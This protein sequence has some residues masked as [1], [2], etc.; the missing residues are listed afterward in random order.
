MSDHAE[1]TALSER[2]VELHG[3]WVPRREPT[4]AAFRAYAARFDGVLNE[5]FVICLRDGGAIVGGVNVNNIVRG[6]FQSGALGYV[7][8]TP[9]AGHGYLT[10]GVA[11]VVRHAF[12]VLGLHRLEA[13]VQPGN[14]RSLRLVRRLGFRYEGFSPA[15]L[16]IN[17]GWRDHERWAITDDMTLSFEP[18][19]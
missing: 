15:F 1:V 18:G 8:Y 14:E 3:E 7:G 10:E 16:H 11:L 12:D 2:S 6:A 19:C 5:G 9:T 17:G 4:E 13:N